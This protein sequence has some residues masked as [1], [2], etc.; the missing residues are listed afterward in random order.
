MAQTK[1]PKHLHI[2]LADNVV[3]AD[4]HVGTGKG[5]AGR[6]HN[7]SGAVGATNVDVGRQFIRNKASGMIVERTVL[8]PATLGTKVDY[9][10][11]DRTSGLVDHEV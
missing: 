2:V 5:C 1:P 11:R 7:W 3:L 4:R 9:G 6:G 8:A 10:V